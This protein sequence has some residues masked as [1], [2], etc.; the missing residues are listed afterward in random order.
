MSDLRFL[1]DSNCF[2]EP[3]KTCYPFCLV[4]AFWETLLRGHTGDMI[5]TLSEVKK[6]IS[7]KEDA[8][9]DWFNQ[10]EFP[11]SFVQKA[12]SETIKQYVVM[13]KWVAQH[14]HFSPVEKNKFADKRTDGYLVAHAKAHNMTVV[15]LEKFAVETH[16]KKVKIP[17]LCQH[18]AV[19]C[20]N[21]F[22]ML[23]QLNVRFVLEQ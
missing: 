10:E 3:S 16:T 13:Q 20:I 5:F 22:E 9:N 4:P 14:P 6:E 1:L 19:E 2:I 23:K 12:T 7:E 18:F 11:D 8:V 21:L 17:N 15:T